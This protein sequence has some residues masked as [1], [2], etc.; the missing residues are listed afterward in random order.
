MT[1][2]TTILVLLI[3]WLSWSGLASAAPLPHTIDIK[4]NDELNLH[5]VISGN[6][7][8][9]ADDDNVVLDSI[10]GLSATADAWILKIT[11]F[12]ND[13]IFD[14]TLAVEGTLFHNQSLTL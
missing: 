12:P 5:V 9:E 1:R 3:L 8:S 10:P 14:D 2:S 6:G 13:G 7:F 4:D 11:F